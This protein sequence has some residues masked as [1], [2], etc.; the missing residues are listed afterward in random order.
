MAIFAPRLKSLPLD[1]DGGSS[2]RPSD[3]AG[4]CGKSKTKNQI[5]FYIIFTNWKLLLK[6]LY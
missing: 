2:G 4:M 3:C 1:F 6:A 5:K